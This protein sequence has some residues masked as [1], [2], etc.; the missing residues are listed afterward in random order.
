M[1]ATDPTNASRTLLMNLRN[2]VTAMHQVAEHNPLVLPRYARRDR[3]LR[4]ARG[5]V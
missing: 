2:V 1:H 5:R 4:H 3:A